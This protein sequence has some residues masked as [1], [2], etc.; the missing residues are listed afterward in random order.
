[1]RTESKTASSVPKCRPLTGAE[2]IFYRNILFGRSQN[3]FETN[4]QRTKI[5][6]FNKNRD[7]VVEKTACFLDAG[8]T[9]NILAALCHELQLDIQNIASVALDT[10]IKFKQDILNSWKLTV[11]PI[12][13]PRNILAPNYTDNSVKTEQRAIEAQVSSPSV[14]DKKDLWL[15]RKFLV[16]L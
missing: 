13:S 4:S 5:L 6:I 8:I 9:E 15:K 1:M 3:H 12:P 14:K 16:P 10:G 7:R 11:I 2:F